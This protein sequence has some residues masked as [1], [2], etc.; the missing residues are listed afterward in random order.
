[1]AIIPDNDDVHA[2]HEQLK[3]LNQEVK[4]VKERVLSSL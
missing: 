1:M 3:E 4:V 2:L